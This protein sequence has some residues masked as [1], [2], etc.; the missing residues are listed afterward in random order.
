[1]VY[2]KVLFQYLS[3]G[4]SHCIPPCK[5]L[6]HRLVGSVP[7][8]KPACFWKTTDEYMHITLCIYNRKSVLSHKE[9]KTVLAEHVHSI[10]S[11]FWTTMHERTDSCMLLQTRSPGHLH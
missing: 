4:S 2:V 11:H 8:N 10:N 3:E 9:H 1:M 7:Q 5:Y 6:N